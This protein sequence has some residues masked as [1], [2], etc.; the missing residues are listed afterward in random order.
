MV[1]QVKDSEIHVIAQ[2]EEGF[3]NKL[4]PGV[5]K[6]LTHSQRERTGYVL[7]KIDNFVL[8]E[9]IYGSLPSKAE[10]V[11]ST[12]Q[13]KPGSLGVLSLGLKGTGK[14]LLSKLIAAM[15]IERLEAPVIV[16]DT[17]SPSQDLNWFIA[18]FDFPCV[19]VMD[20]FEK[21]FID[22]SDGDDG[23]SDQTSLLTM[24][25][26]SL[27]TPHLFL[28]SANYRYKINPS[29][30]NRPGRIRYLFEF[31]GL[32]PDAVREYAEAALKDQSKV[33]DVVLLTRAYTSISFDTLQAII[34]EMNLYGESATQVLEVLN[35]APEDDS[36]DYDFEVMFGD[37]RADI[38]WPNHSH[39]MPIFD[40]AFNIRGEV[41]LSKDLYEEA[42]GY[43]IDKSYDS[44]TG[45]FD[46][47]INLSPGHLEY[48]DAAA[49]YCVYR[50]GPIRVEF[51]RRQARVYSAALGYDNLKAREHKGRPEDLERPRAMV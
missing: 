35:A 16:I 9:K 43:T 20:E 11:L 2:N 32:E 50:L 21:V 36:Y 13:A 24:L 8:P 23:R 6:L 5:Y 15:A 47:Q 48:V 4:E 3:M 28:L 49:G 46:F 38:S 14:S 17:I 42:K 22:N 37:R 7:Q 30:I 45:D 27:Q 19:W 44:D 10:R 18:Q 1:L 41:R 39:G 34:E 12:F 29:L 26:G 51:R 40:K 31:Y 33:E 25:D